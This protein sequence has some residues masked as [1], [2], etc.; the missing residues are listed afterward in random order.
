MDEIK[1]L[2]NKL[3]SIIT[4]KKESSIFSIYPLN[5]EPENLTVLRC[6]FSYLIT[7]AFSFV[8][9]ENK[10][11]ILNYIDDLESKFQTYQEN[12]YGVSA[13]DKLNFDNDNIDLIDDRIFCI[14]GGLSSILA[15]TP[16]KAFVGQLK[17]YIINDFLMI[18]SFVQIIKSFTTEENMHKI[19]KIENN[20][21][22]FCQKW[23][24]SNVK[25]YLENSDTESIIIAT[26]FI[27]SIIH[28]IHNLQPI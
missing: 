2:I 10:N 28:I 9:I 16:D 3:T 21:L 20:L 6:R 19:I 8:S 24:K 14:S 5:V 22:Y 1:D 27:N 18:V 17:E 11:K 25:Y 23:N 4:Q 7:S 12:T 13:Y 26:D 15:T